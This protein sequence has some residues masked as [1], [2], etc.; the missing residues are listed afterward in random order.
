MNHLFRL[1]NTKGVQL[2]L[3]ID[4]VTKE[5]DNPHN[6]EVGSMIQFQ[7]ANRPRYGVIVWIGFLPKT[8]DVTVAGL[9]LVSRYVYIKIVVNTL[10]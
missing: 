7:Y 5:D 3:P 2:F 8:N 9:V 4:L 10:A 6:L 1:H